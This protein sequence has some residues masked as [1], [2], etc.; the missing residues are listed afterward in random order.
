MGTSDNWRTVTLTTGALITQ[1]FI[2]YTERERERERGVRRS[3]DIL[4]ALSLIIIASMHS[5][6]ILM[7]TSKHSSHATKIKFKISIIIMQLLDMLM[8]EKERKK[9]VSKQLY[10]AD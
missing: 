6:H 8:S 1:D 10:N 3:I 2:L 5:N 4:I 7:N 9:A